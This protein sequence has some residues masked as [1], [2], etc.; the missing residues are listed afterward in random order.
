MHQICS[1]LFTCLPA[2]F[3]AVAWRRTSVSSM[4]PRFPIN[5]SNCA[6]CML[7]IYTSCVWLVHHNNCTAPRCSISFGLKST[8]D[9]CNSAKAPHC[10]IQKPSCASTWALGNPPELTCHDTISCS[11]WVAVWGLEAQTDPSHFGDFKLTAMQQGCRLIRL[12][13]GLPRSCCQAE[14]SNPSSFAYTGL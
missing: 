7:A 2:S 5:N 12:F 14:M 10:I 3:T 13:F 9:S 8:F 6:K 1:H 11:T 4:A